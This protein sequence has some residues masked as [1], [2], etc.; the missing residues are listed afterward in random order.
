MTGKLRGPF[1]GVFAIAGPAE[2]GE[3]QS[4]SDGHIYSTIRYGRRRMPAYHA[5]PIGR[6]LGHRELRPLPERQTSVAA[7]AEGPAQ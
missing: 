1:A 5:H 2:H 4:R 7:A 6:P 3:L